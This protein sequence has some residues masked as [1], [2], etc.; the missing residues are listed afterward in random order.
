VI[1]SSGEPVVIQVATVLVGV[2][3]IVVLLLI[4]IPK[5]SM[6][7]FRACRE[8]NVPPEQR[9]QPRPGLGSLFAPRRPPAERAPVGRTSVR[10]T[11]PAETRPA[12]AKAKAKVRSDSDAVAKGAELARARA[13]AS[14]SRRTG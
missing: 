9:G 12:V 1:P 10:T 7:Y 2:L 11:Q 14:K 5:Q 4:F 6:A 13:K 8:A 3:S